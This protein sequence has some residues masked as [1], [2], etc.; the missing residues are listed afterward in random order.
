M[1]Y[2]YNSS[3]IYA[4]SWS[5][6]PL[7]FDRVSDTVKGSY[8]SNAFDKYLFRHGQKFTTLLKSVYS[9]YPATN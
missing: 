7:N 2:V 9:R 5:I 1:R 4:D 6:V 8:A 3:Y